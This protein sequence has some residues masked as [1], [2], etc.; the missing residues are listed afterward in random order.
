[1]NIGDLNRR[2]C[3]LTNQAERDSF[4]A[5]VNKWIIVGRVWAKIVPRIG[6]ES[7][8]NEQEQG[9]QDATITMRFYPAMNLNYRIQYGDTFYEVK[10]VKDIKTGHRWTEVKVKEIIDG[11][12]RKAEEIES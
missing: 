11:I 8:I 9:L 10:A 5:I 6:R 7:F 12:Q 4:G 2:I 3:I 1:M